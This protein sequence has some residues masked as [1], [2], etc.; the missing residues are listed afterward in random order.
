[1]V[2]ITNLSGKSQGGALLGELKGK[3]LLGRSNYRREANT[4]LD[5]REKRIGVRG[6]HSICLE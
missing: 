1:M 5:L 4:E 3:R 2:Y 6:K